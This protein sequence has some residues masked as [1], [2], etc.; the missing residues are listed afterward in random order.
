MNEDYEKAIE[1]YPEMK[2]YAES[3]PRQLWDLFLPLDISAFV[4]FS[5]TI[6]ALRIKEKERDYI[7][8]LRK[9]YDLP[10]RPNTS[11]EETIKRVR[12]I[13]WQRKMQA[14][15]GWTEEAGENSGADKIDPDEELI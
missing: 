6:K 9:K 4:E 8:E 10:F 14:E 5:V 7:V 1:K 15:W 2:Q 11:I 13:R 3:I 12:L